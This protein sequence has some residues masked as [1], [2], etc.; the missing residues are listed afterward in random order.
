MSDDRQAE[1]EARAVTGGTWRR[2][3]SGG[4]IKSFKMAFKG[5]D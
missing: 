1:S 5:A 4:K 3:E 2:L